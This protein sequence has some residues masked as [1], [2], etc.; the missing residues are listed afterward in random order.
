M[1]PIM[2]L[3]AEYVQL[4]QRRVCLAKPLQSCIADSANSEIQQRQRALPLQHGR[5]ARG[6]VIVSRAPA[7]IRL[8]QPP[9]LHHCFS[10]RP[11]S[12]RL[13]AQLERLQLRQ[14]ADGRH[15]AFYVV[16][17]HV[18]HHELHNLQPRRLLQQ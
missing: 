14:L 11:D 1:S 18:V 9:L 13:P 16:L 3:V 2:S 15:N 17:V 10:K 5:Q 8:P 6:S 7:K 4:Q 12:N